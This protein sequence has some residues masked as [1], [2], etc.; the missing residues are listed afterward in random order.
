MQI[1]STL[2]QGFFVTGTNTGVGKTY[3]TSLLA[4]QFLAQGK[5]VGVYKPVAS[6]CIERD[7]SWVSEDAEQ[8]WIAAGKPQSI[9]AVTPQL[10][11]A[12]VAP[13][14]AARM[15]GKCVNA[16]ALR[17]GL[18]A[19]NGYDVTLVEGVGGLMSPLSDSDLVIDLAVE[20]SFPIIVV[21]GNEL[22][23]INQTLQTIEVAKQ[24]QLQIAGIIL[25][26]ATKARDDSCL[27]NQAE[28][29]RWTDVP[30]VGSLGWGD[31]EIRQ[32]VTASWLP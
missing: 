19:W 5:R 12:A 26:S 18:H 29:S 20:F 15:E 4:K 13:N 3:V 11:A 30:I 24:R 17:E 28:I 31:K 1:D 7:G 10:F 21:V 14:V 22:G 27:T 6:G 32:L 16:T 25:N 23:C 8:L 9:D 2:S